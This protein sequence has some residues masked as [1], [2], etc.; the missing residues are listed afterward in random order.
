MNKTKAIVV[1]F[2]ISLLLFDSLV[3]AAPPPQTAITAYSLVVDRSIS[4]SGLI[5]RVVLPAGIACPPLIATRMGRKITVES[6]PRHPGTSTHPAFSQVNVCEVRIPKGISSAQIGGK[7]VPH[8]IPVKVRRLGI[9]GD[10]GCSIEPDPLAPGADVQNCNDPKSWPLAQISESLAKNRP[11]VLL[12]LGDFQ[13][14]EGNCPES[15]KE[16]CGGTPSPVTGWVERNEGTFPFP[17]TAYIW[18]ADFILPAAPLL[19]QTPMVVVRGNHEECHRG[20]VGY[21]LFFHPEWQNGDACAPTG[22][23]TPDIT[24]PN[25]VVN[26]P[27]SQQRRLRL[28]VMDSAIS[29]NRNDRA[30]VP[31]LNTQKQD[32]YKDAFAKSQGSSETWLLTHR[33]IFSIL[34]SNSEYK[35]RDTP[36]TSKE[37]Q[38]ASY[39]F[40]SQYNLILSS[41]LHLAQAVQVPGIPGQL[42]IGNGGALLDTPTGYVIPPF[43]PLADSNNQPINIGMTPYAPASHLWTSVSFG[44]SIAVPKADR[45]GWTFSMRTPDGFQAAS[46][47]LTGQQIHCQ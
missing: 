25:Y 2:S 44:Y 41:H 16:W 15:Q 38:V 10:T 46:C 33:P 9:L 6:I 45:S 36:W 20:G 1:I 23:T 42:T 22:Q 29:P 19:A 3:E 12:Y 37:E 5:G 39:G 21:Y 7:S 30:P 28:V 43:G 34:S 17:D 13:Y 8:R 31:F 11:D 14:R 18:L 47:E 27:I 40:I 24:S 26:L 4:P 32:L 35:E